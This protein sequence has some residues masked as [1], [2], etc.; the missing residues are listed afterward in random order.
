MTEVTAKRP[1]PHIHHTDA[2]EAAAATV[3]AA[4]TIGKKPG[5]ALLNPLDV[6]QVREALSGCAEWFEDPNFFF[7]GSEPNAEQTAVEHLIM[8]ATL[9][10][11]HLRAGNTT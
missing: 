2:L 11:E 9:L 10:R 7:E 4:I 1:I 8:V 6:Q 5:I 3:T